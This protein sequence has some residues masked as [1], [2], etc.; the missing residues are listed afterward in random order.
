MSGDVTLYILDNVPD[1]EWSSDTDF[2]FTR[3]VVIDTTVEGGVSINL[4]NL[5]LFTVGKNLTVSDDVEILKVGQLGTYTGNSVTVNSAIKA[6]Q[7]WAYEG[8]FKVVPG[9][10]VNFH[11]GD[12]Q[13][14][15]WSGGKYEVEGGFDEG[16]AITLNP[17]AATPQING[18]YI[19]F[20]YGND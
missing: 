13:I 16:D 19:K 15:M 6:Y 18:G 4:D 17:V 2:E 9:G 14:G 1:S 12:G 20:F 7:L 11:G 8:V 10:L 3:N 5:N